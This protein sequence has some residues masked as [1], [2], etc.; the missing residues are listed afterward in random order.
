[1]ILKLRASPG[2]DNFGFKKGRKESDD[3]SVFVPET[4]SIEAVGLPLTICLG[5]L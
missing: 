3:V 5:W 2:A 4:A 1:L